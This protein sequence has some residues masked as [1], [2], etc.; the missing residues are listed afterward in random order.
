MAKVFKHSNDAD[1]KELAIFD[2]PATNTSVYEKRFLNYHPISG[3]TP[4]T[5]VIH[6]SIKGNSLK[7]LD[8]PNSRLFIRCKIAP[9]SDEQRDATDVVFPVNHMFQSMWQ[10]VEIFLGGKLVSTGSTNFHYKSMIKTLLKKCQTQA[11][12]KKLCSEMFA[13]DMAGRHD[14]LDPADNG[15]AFFR[16]S[17]T[18][19]NV[20]IE[21]EGSLNED[22]LDID[23]YIINGVDL[24]IKLYP[25][26]GSIALMSNNVE[27]R[28]KI[29]FTEA[30]WKCCVVDVG[31][32]I[33]RAHTEALQSGG[34]AQYFFKQMSM[35]NYAIPKGQRNYSETIFQGN[36]PQKIFIAMVG[37]GRYNGD[38]ELNPFKFEHFNIGQIAILVNDVSRPHRPVEMNFSTRRYLTALCNLLRMYNNVVI[39]YDTFPNGYTIF[40]FDV[41]STDNGDD[42]LTLRQSGNVRLEMQ[43]DKELDESVQV[44]VCGEYESCIQIDNTR[45]V[46]YT[47]L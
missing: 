45:A 46:F 10:Q 32:S 25:I 12:K 5:N 11:M 31:H 19:G 3:I 37:A 27:K 38:Y 43:F 18:N 24:D 9:E 8:L 36:L 6:F 22:V 34:L 40:V 44:L 23:K 42:N 17:A 41:N 20:D 21:M 14:Q 15:G 13:E 28:Y 4:T 2:T 39:D 29:F 16:H 7:Y 35:N 1:I 47:P 26:R 33:V 30:I